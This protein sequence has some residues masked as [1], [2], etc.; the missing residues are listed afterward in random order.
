MSRPSAA[1]RAGR[2][3]PDAWPRSP[4]S[5]LP[6][7][8]DAATLAAEVRAKVHSA[9]RPH[10]PL[11]DFRR[12]CRAGRFEVSQA[13]L[14]AGTRQQEALLIPL[15]GDRFGICIDPTPPGGWGGVRRAVRPELRRHRHRFRVAHEIAHT[16]FYDR[17][18]GRPRRVF[19]G[20]DAEETFCDEFARALLLPAEAVRSRPPIAESVFSLHRDYTVSVEVAARAVA[21]AHQGVQVALW[22]KHPND[23][24]CLQWTTTTPGRAA[25]MRARAEEDPARGQAIAIWRAGR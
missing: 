3:Q 11:A 12:I 17:T 7:L 6:K 25:R 10:E 22:Y 13:T 9:D 24:W 15:D 8:A 23:G 19:P 18:G 14:S 1:T 16:F 20:S 2:Q 21:V 4:L 5:K